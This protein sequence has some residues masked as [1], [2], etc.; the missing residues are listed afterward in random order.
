MP[1][2]ECLRGIGFTEPQA[3]SIL[4]P[5]ANSDRELNPGLSSDM[6]GFTPNGAA[7]SLSNWPIEFR[8]PSVLRVF[9]HAWEWTGFLNYTKA[10][11]QYQGDL[12]PQNQF[13]YYFT[14]QLGGRVYATGFNQEGYFVTA[15]GLTDLSTG[16]ITSI[17]DL[18]NPFA[19]VDIPTYYPQL[20]VDNLNVTTTLELNSGCSITG[21]PLFSPEWYTNFRIATETS[22]GLVSLSTIKSLGFSAGTRIAFNNASPP[23][24][25]VTVT[26]PTHNDATIR[27]LN[28][29]GGGVGGSTAFTGVFTGT[30]S[31]SINLTTSGSVNSHTLSIAELA[32][33]THGF[34]G[35]FEYDTSQDG[36]T[37]RELINQSSTT[38]ATGSSAGHGHGFTNASY[39]MGDM[40]FN[41]KYVDFIVA[42]KS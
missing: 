5:V 32:S 35:A 18:G 19:G 10:L 30:R 23:T 37:D 25:W 31:S 8:R 14:N 9:G 11:P 13:T 33:H 29:S 36:P 39:S 2:Y 22:P 12:S 4:L 16:A 15:A 6:K 38:D 21:A 1:I 3:T 17:T 41:V 27:I 20:T 26:D 42:Q 40:N 7:N 34:T 28:S 24:G